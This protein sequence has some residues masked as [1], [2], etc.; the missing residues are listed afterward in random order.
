MALLVLIKASSVKFMI[1]V[2]FIKVSTP[3]ALLNL[4]VPEV[5]KV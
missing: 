3:R 1:D 2:L 4:A 5:G